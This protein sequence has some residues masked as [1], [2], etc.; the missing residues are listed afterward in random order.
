M[1]NRLRRNCLGLLICGWARLACA[2]SLVPTKPQVEPA[3]GLLGTWAVSTSSYE[4][5]HRVS[6]TTTIKKTV[7]VECNV[8]A[9]LTFKANGTGYV[10]TEGGDEVL[11]RFRW[12]VAHGTLLFTHDKTGG[13]GRTALADGSYRIMPLADV[14]GNPAVDLVD[15]R[16]TRQQLLKLERPDV[17]PIEGR[18]ENANKTAIFYRTLTFADLAAVFTSAG[19]T[20]YRFHYSVHHL[21]PTRTLWLRDAFNTRRPAHILK[22]SQDSLVFDQL[23]D[24]STP[25]HFYRSKAK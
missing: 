23:W 2:Q 20:V 5:V 7:S 9:E 6:K 13:N 4:S 16:N 21:P 10:A 14:L 12:H 18:W 17:T 1:R 11:S 15:R 19:D 25:Q 22:A 24:L 3:A 8:C